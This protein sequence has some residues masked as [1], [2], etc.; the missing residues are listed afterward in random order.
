MDIVT[1][2]SLIVGAISLA[3]A[4]YQS[5]KVSKINRLR[6]SEALLLHKLSGLALGAIQG[7]N[8]STQML[9]K[10]PASSNAEKII[11]DI[12]LSEGYCQSLYVETAKTFCNLKNITTQEIDEMMKNGQLEETHKHVYMAFANKKR[13][14]SK[15]LK[16]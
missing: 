10:A 15:C 3:L 9:Q 4:I 13:K 11:Y 14:F 5:W 2:I 8:N 6:I 16:T 12:G 7:N 1:L